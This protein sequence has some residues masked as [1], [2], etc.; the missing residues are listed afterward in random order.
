MPTDIVLSHNQV[1]LLKRSQNEGFRKVDISLDLGITRTKVELLPDGVIL[2]PLEMLPWDSIDRISKSK[3]SCFKV[4]NGQI[5]KIAEFSDLTN[6]L[7]SLLPTEHAPTLMISGIPMHRIK[8]I[9]PQQDILENIKTL[10]PLSGIVLDT[11]TGSGYT[12]IEAAKYA[13]K[14][15][16]IEIDPAALK[17]AKCNP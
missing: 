5:H 12:A 10:Q 15:I 17:I 4:I 11:A 7:Y 3:N 2:N 9:D 13:S 8:G 1:N 16:T 6:Q 14:V